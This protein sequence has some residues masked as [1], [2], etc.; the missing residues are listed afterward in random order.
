MPD[1]D[2]KPGAGVTKPGG[3]NDYPHDGTYRPGYHEG[4]SRF[5]FFNGEDDASIKAPA[6]A[7]EPPDKS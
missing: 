2:D 1:R 7:G 3:R 5:G 6:G 4:G